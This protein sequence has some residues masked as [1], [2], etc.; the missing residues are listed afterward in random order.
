MVSFTTF[1]RYFYCSYNTPR[2]IRFSAF[3]S[4]VNRLRMAKKKLFVARWHNPSVFDYSAIFDNS[5]ESIHMGRDV[6]NQFSN[7]KDKMKMTMMKKIAVKN[8][9]ICRH[10]N[11][12]CKLCSQNSQS[13][14]HSV[15]FWSSQKSLLFKLIEDLFIYPIPSIVVVIIA[16]FCWLLK[17]L[18]I[19]IEQS[20]HIHNSIGGADSYKRKHYKLECHQF[21]KSS[22]RRHLSQ[23]IGLFLINRLIQSYL[24]NLLMWSFWNITRRRSVWEKNV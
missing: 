13:I 12:T 7:R 24:I 14:N 19:M 9:H 10:R 3:D 5:T 18:A 4:M 11:I 17:R 21:M 8:H 23:V 6:N 15:E 20:T 1:L 22:S 16:F 2:G